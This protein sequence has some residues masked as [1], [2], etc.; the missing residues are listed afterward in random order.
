MSYSYT[1]KQT[2]TSSEG[3][4]IGGGGIGG[5]GS[6][7]HSVSGIGRGASSSMSSRRYTPTV[8]SSQGFSGGSY[9][10]GRS[11][12]SCAGGRC[13]SMSGGFGGGS[14][15]GG[16]HGGGSFG[17][18]FGGGHIGGGF[19]GGHGG[20]HQGGGYGGG[21]GG[22]G[23]GGDDAGFLSNNEKSTMQ[24]LN[25]RLASY[26]EKVRHLE[27]ENNQ[28][29]SLIKE[30]YQTHSQTSEPKDYNSYYEEINKLI[31]E[32]ISESLESNKI[33]LDVDNARMAAE[34]FKLKYETESGLHQNVDADLQGLRPLLDKLTLDKSDLEMQYESLQEELATLRK[35]HDDIMKSSQHH[36]SGDVSIEVNAAPGQDLQKALNELRQEY[37]EI[38]A[39]NRSEVEQ[40]YEAKMEE[41]RQQEN[42]GN[43]ETGSGSSQVTE[44]TRELQTLEIELQ[45]QLST[46]QLLQRNLNNTEGGY[47]MQLQHLG[48]LIEP[49]E[50]ELAGIKG[51]IQNQTQEYQTLLGIKT[52]LEQEISQY[53]QLLE[54]GNHLAY[55]EIMT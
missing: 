52:H 39:K 25:D 34:D 21:T 33:L 50:T 4:N 48:S 11:S 22:V 51:E 28:L 20:G 43:Q 6:G 26:L 3:G 18:G 36:S 24:N 14:S 17:G 55:V 5:G 8:R 40:W 23:F 37:E 16:S 13:R 46:I 27:A 49:V 54:E 32:L 10:G 15:F 42:T 45:T 41:A 44:L 30:W 31:S 19:G 35:N 47:N 53:H 29:E 2:Q 7:G 1:F 9:G 12:H 38:I